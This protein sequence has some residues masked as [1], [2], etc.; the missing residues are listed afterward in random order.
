METIPLQHGLYNS[1]YYVK[2]DPSQNQNLSISFERP[3]KELSNV[4]I[5]VTALQS[6]NVCYFLCRRMSGNAISS[7]PPGNFT[8]YPNLITLDLSDNLLTE[9]PT[10]DIPQLTSLYVH[11]LAALLIL[12]F[13][14]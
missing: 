9:V 7:L 12:Y 11:S 13:I 6:F 3:Y 4:L 1:F 5:S 10:L 8:A 14:A 2:I